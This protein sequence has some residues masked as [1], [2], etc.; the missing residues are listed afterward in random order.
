MRALSQTV[1]YESVIQNTSRIVDSVCFS[2]RG[3]GEGVAS[4]NARAWDPEIRDG[5]DRLVGV[6]G[7]HARFIRSEPLPAQAAREAGTHGRENQRSD[8]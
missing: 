4:H 6:E 1:V 2:Y 8:W 3:R 7:E 5:K